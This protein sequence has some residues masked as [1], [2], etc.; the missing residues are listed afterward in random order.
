MSRLM[1][2]ALRVARLIGPYPRCV[3]FGHEPESPAC[4]VTRC[5]HCGLSVTRAAGRWWA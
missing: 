4:I 3:D 2:R 5:R 1:R